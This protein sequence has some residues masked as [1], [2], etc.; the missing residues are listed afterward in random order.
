MNSNQT[1]IKPQQV[2]GEI[3]ISSDVTI[4]IKSDSVS[5][6]NSKISAEKFI[7]E[8]KDAFKNNIF[9]VEDEPA[10]AK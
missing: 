3:K 10:V 9:S 2:S 1:K 6:N 4:M 8:L 5:N 7:R